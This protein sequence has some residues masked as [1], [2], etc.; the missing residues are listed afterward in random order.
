MTERGWKRLLGSATGLIVLATSSMAVASEHFSIAPFNFQ[1]K[2]KI[3]TFH[4]PTVSGNTF[5]G[6][7]SYRPA[8]VT[9]T[10]GTTFSYS[11]AFLSGPMP[12]PL[13]IAQEYLWTRAG[14]EPVQE[15]RAPQR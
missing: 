3:Y 14:Q 2:K 1:A 7:L 13:T 4:A 10:V 6:S 5:K 11:G 8:A 12:S 9:R 15:P